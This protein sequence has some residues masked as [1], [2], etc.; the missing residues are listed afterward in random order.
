MEIGTQFPDRP[1]EWTSL[2]EC[3]LTPEGIVT[4]NLLHTPDGIVPRHTVPTGPALLLS[5]LPLT[6]ASALITDAAPAHTTDTH[7]WFDVSLRVNARLSLPAHADSPDVRYAYLPMDATLSLDSDGTWLVEAGA[8]QR[9][10]TET[11]N[12]HTGDATP[13]TNPSDPSPAEH[14]FPPDTDLVASFRRTL[15]N[16]ARS[17]GVVTMATLCRGAYLP[18][19]ALSVDR[20]QELLLQVEQLWTPEKP[21]LSALIK[22]QDGGPAP[23]FGKV[24]RGL[25]WGKKF[26]DAELLDICN[27][28]RRRAHAAYSRSNQANPPSPRGHAAHRRPPERLR[29]EQAESRAVF[30][31]LLDLAHEARHA[32][33]LDGLERSLFLAEQAAG[34]TD[35]QEA[36]RDLTD[37]LVERR[38]DELHETWERLSALVDK[39]NRDGDDLHPDQLRRALREAHDLT[40]EVGDDLAAE[41]R[42]DIAR[43]QQHLERMTERLTLSQIRGYAVAVRVALRRAAREGRTTTW[44]E[45]ALRIGAPLAA[46]HPDDKV[47]VLIEADRETP[48][49]K[50]LLSALVAA[51][52]GDRPHPLYPQ[53]LFSLDRPTPPAEALLMH[54]HMTLRRHAELR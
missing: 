29:G 48:E 5:G 53:V 46:L 2:S 18:D 1:V 24:L 44:G 22:G 30:D 42:H 38:T 27:R 28:E 15:E 49:D 8:L 26:S 47:A 50:P 40:E 25:G 10:P 32:G 45:M 17:R 36:L 33:D 43:W 23:F 6:P 51:H 35:T 19:H 39:I 11:D 34:T 12:R 16:T 41:E 14:S 54:W 20:W 4:P 13:A 21:V 9:I 7:R 31:A 52:G 37:W 3:T